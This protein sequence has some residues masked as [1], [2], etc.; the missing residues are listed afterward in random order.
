MARKKQTKI[1]IAAIQKH[2]ELMEHYVSLLR[3]KKHNPDNQADWVR[4]TSEERII[5]EAIG[6]TVMLEFILKHQNSYNGFTDVDENMKPIINDWDKYPRY[7]DNPDY[8][9]WRVIYH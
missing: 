5:G 4:E 1:A 6:A 9:R 8:A 7:E 3:L 2:K